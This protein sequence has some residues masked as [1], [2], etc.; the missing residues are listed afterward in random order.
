MKKILFVCLL[1][2]FLV[3]NSF[4]TEKLTPQQEIQSLRVQIEQHNKNYYEFDTPT[5]SDY[6]YDKLFSRLKCLE[7]KY[8]ECVSKD[9][10][11]QKVGA[12]TLKKF[13]QINHKYPLYSLDKCN[14]YEELKKWDK[15]VKKDL[16][17]ENIDYDAELKIDGL[18]VSLVYEK[19]ALKT[20]ATR[21]NGFIGED[22]T[23]NIKYVEGIPQK[24]PQPLNLQVGG[25]VYMPFVSFDKL[26]TEAK[27]TFANPRNAAAGSLR[28][29]DENIT[30]E[31]G[32]KFF[33][34]GVTFEDKIQPETQT[35]LLQNLKNLGFSVNPE[36]K[37]L[38]NIDEAINFC[39]TWDEKRFDL[40][41]PIDG[42]VT[43]VND[44]NLE[45]KL[46]NTSHA[47]RWAIAYKYRTESSE[48][49]LLKI[50]F[51][52]G[53]TGIV[54]PVAIFEPVELGGAKVQ[55]AGLHNFDEIEQMDLRIGDKIVVN[56]S[57]EIIPQIISVD[58]S[59]RVKDSKKFQFPQNCPSCGTKLVKNS[60]EKTCF[61]PNPNCSEKNIAKLEFFVSRQG[62]DIKGLGRST[63]EKLFKSG[64]V[65]TP[66]DIYELSESDLTKLDKIGS[67]SAQKIYTS[68][69]NSKNMPLANFINALCIENVGKEKSKILAEKFDSIDN[70]VNAK[71]ED[72]T[73]IPG[74]EDKIAQNIVNYF[75][76]PKNKQEL[77]KFKRYGVIK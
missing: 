31:R 10:P 3:G 11:T 34:Y 46:G 63:C 73:K 6:E 27:Q 60:S 76:N 18:A 7:K 40:E 50:E 52:V 59:A 13:K 44:R 55:R 54:T 22:I 16:K 70:L 67:K 19:G 48:T 66:A 71:K 25:E 14:S 42:I 58:K 61:C 32:L 9:S 30:K 23:K 15:K 29:L 1:I 51:Q 2:F 37:V 4:A 65:K 74:I 75:K 45:K 56:Q 36:T 69:Q 77:A 17:T 26:N 8:P 20:A 72:L 12:D 35:E 38:K 43:K 5:I 39:K 41:Y 64:L 28:Q 53:K 21:G 57:N 68:I 33:A 24:L 47:P 62:M 49:T